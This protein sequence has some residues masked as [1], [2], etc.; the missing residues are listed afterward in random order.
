[1][2]R[3]AVALGL[4]LTLALTLRFT[5]HG[6]GFTVRPVQGSTVPAALRAAR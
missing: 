6:S 3:V 1:M 5:V 2:R 4:G